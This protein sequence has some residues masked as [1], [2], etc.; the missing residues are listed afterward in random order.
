MN[1]TD[2]NRY[3]RQRILPEIGAN[4]QAKLAQ[5]TVF[6]VGCG[7]LGCFQAELLARAGLGRLRIADRDLVE[8]SNLQRQVLF[9]ESDA[10][11]SVSKAEAAE[12]ASA[13]DQFHHRRR[14]AGCRCDNAKR[15][16]AAGGR[17]SC[18][19]RN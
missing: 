4:G 9:E 6:I 18:P 12:E 3:A 10:A 13:G 11:A 8:W 15:R 14:I 19:R 7:A 17:R 16:I 5:S 2:N 1:S